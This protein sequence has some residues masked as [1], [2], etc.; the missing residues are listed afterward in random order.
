MIKM[1]L[2]AQSNFTE[3]LKEN[4]AV[5]LKVDISGKVQSKILYFIEYNNAIKLKS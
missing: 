5:F 4:I 2:S 3:P 1:A